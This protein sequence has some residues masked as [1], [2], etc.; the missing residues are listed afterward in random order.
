MESPNEEPEDDVVDVPPQKVVKKL[1]SNFIN[2]HKNREKLLKATSNGCKKAKSNGIKHTQRHS[3][4]LL[5]SSSSQNLAKSLSLS[6]SSSSEDDESS[7]SNPITSKLTSSQ[8]IKSPLTKIVTKSSAKKPTA[9]R[10]KTLTRKQKN[11]VKSEDNGSSD[12]EVDFASQ[13]ESLAATY[14]LVKNEIKNEIKDESNE[15]TILPPKVSPKKSSLKSSL[16][17]AEPS[18][19]KDIAS[20]LALGEG[21]SFSEDDEDSD[22]KEVSKSEVS[23]LLNLSKKK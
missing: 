7:S 22:E 18:T 14:T 8:A 5:P 10:K 1:P 19:S 2:N 21:V 16:I 15:S 17:K 11:L 3:G 6:E 4:H 23:Q 9:T 13:L 12:E 20:L